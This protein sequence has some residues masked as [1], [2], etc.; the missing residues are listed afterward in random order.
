MAKKSQTL[1]IEPTNSPEPGQ[2]PQS[3]AL[4]PVLV[5]GQLDRNPAAIYLATLRPVG[6][7]GMLR[8]LT[9]VAEI[10]SDSRETALTL[11]W[12]QLRYQHTAAIAAA[13]VERGYRPATINQAL[14]GLRSVLYHAWKLGLMESED[15]QRARD[16][17]NRKADNLLRGRA[18]DKEE[19]RTIIKNCQEEKSPAGVRDAALVGV[20]YGTGLRRSEVVKLELRDYNRKNGGLTIWGAK[21][22]KDRL[23]YAKGGAAKALAAWLLLRSEEPGP[24]FCPVH[25]SGKIRLEAMT[26]QAIL[27]ILKKRGFQAELEPFSPH[28][29]RRTY[30]SD[31]LDAGADIA[32][33]Q[34]LA[35][36]ASV[37]TTARYDRRGEDA[38]SKASEL[39]NIPF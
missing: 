21:G 38:K 24:L 39:L 29:L 26:D 2:D 13:L 11:P 6:R 18:L 36:H 28:D 22:G 35:G 5:S 16:V 37:T 12:H 34:K 20:M 19:L 33:V 30:I 27:K 3:V 1:E 10:A 17:K 8:A 14:S 31:L 25:K 32:T 9:L 4:A 15:Y 23:V 7:R